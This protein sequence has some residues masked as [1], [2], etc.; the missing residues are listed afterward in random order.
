MV[1]DVSIDK[2]NDTIEFNEYLKMMYKTKTAD[3]SESEL[4][5]AIQ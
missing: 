2:M 4:S 3:V 1:R 5:E